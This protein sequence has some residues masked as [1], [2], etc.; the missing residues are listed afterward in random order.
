MSARQDR[1]HHYQSAV[2]RYYEMTN[3]PNGS[4]KV[5]EEKE[6]PYTG[7]I[8][9]QSQSQPPNLSYS[10]HKNSKA[11]P[12]R[13]KSNDNSII[14]ELLHTLKSQL[15]RGEERQ[16]SIGVLLIFTDF[17]SILTVTFTIIPIITI[18]SNIIS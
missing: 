6:V 1:D 2:Y 8:F 14:T 16:S 5:G 15:Q 18:A 9:K 11:N 12:H 3:N 17:Q 7:G 4:P 10:Y 13:S